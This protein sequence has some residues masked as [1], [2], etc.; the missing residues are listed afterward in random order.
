MNW[1]EFSKLGKTGRYAVESVLTPH[2]MLS[3]AL[4]RFRETG[5]W[6]SSRRFRVEG[7]PA[8]NSR[9]LTLKA[10][11]KV[12]ARFGGEVVEVIPTRQDLAV[13]RNRGAA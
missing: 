6:Y 1:D 8:G 11:N 10:A 5:K 4:E 12:K 9:L 3:I 13:Q 2:E 7:S